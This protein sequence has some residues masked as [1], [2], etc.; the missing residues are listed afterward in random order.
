M[1]TILGS[2]GAVSIPLAQHL[3]TYTD[4]IR[5]V[6]RTPQRVNPTD[7]LVPANLLN[8]AEVDA[9]VAGSSIV[10]LT[11]GLSYRTKLWQEQWPIVIQNVLQACRNHQAR[12]VFLDNIYALGYV[13]G[14]MTE[15]TPLNPVSKKGEVR[16]KIARQLQGENQAGNVEILIARAPDFY[17]PNVK[18]SVIDITVIQN[19][20]KGKKAQWLVNSEVKHSFIFTP[21]AGHAMALLGNTPEAFGQIWH[22]PTAAPALTGAEFIAACAQELGVSSKF[23]TLPKWMVQLGGLFVPDLKESVEMLYQYEHEYLFDSSKFEK[24]F[25]FQPT[26]YQEGIRIST[27]A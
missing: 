5:L 9:A 12:L 24:H 21:D 22:L 10:Y 25:D 4:E 7:M 2:G 8:A 13:Q 6:S 15:D 23:T 19:L 16:A 26:S 17:G 1:Q 18:T 11:A 14:P 3:R 27:R 20:K